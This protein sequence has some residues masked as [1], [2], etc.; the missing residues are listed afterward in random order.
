MALAQ[1][2]VLVV[3]GVAVAVVPCG[4]LPTVT[5]S[6]AGFL[7]V[8]PLAGLLGQAPP[9]PAGRPGRPGTGPPR[10]P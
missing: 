5:L 1:V 3:V 9:G 6:L 4:L 8:A 10:G 2:V 7:L